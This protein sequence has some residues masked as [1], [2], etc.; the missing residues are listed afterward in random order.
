MRKDPL[1]AGIGRVIVGGVRVS[2]SK[3]FSEVL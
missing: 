1:Q 2:F 3:I